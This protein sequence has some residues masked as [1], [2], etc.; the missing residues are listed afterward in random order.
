MRIELQAFHISTWAEMKTLVQASTL[1][2]GN[3]MEELTALTQS[4]S[5]FR[6]ASVLCFAETWLHEFARLSVVSLRPYYLH[7]EFSHTII[8]TIYIP[9]TANTLRANDVISSATAR[10][11]T[12]HPS[13]FI[14]ISGDFI[15]ANLSSSLPTFKQFVDCKTRDSKTLD[16]LYASVKGRIQLHSSPCSQQI[17]SQSGRGHWKTYRQ[18]HRLRQLLYVQIIPTKTV[19]CFPNNK[20]WVTKDTLNR[21]KATFRRGDK[22]ELKKVQTELREK[23]TEGKDCYRRKLKSRQQNRTT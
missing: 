4:D 9:P 5:V 23:I 14:A 18:H 11:Q 22:E 8:I 16:L 21:K 12:L 15:H 7:R 10:L 13:A 20:P 17:R 3:K 19:R 6:E 2:M 1:I